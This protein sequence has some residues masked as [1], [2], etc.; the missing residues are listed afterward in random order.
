M[1]LMVCDNVFQGKFGFPLP[2]IKTMHYFAAFRAHSHW[3]KVKA[4]VKNFSL[5]FTANSYDKHTLS[6]LDSAT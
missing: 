3:S 1:T 2:V 6:V 5:I 4:R